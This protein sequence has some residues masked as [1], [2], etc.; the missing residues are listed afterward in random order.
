[1]SFNGISTQKEKPGL[2]VVLFSSSNHTIWAEEVLKQEGIEV[3]LIPVPR[4]LSADCGYCVQ[5]RSHDIPRIQMLFQGNS[6]KFD[7]IAAI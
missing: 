2:S 5:V 7:R 6:V 3:K 4:H 1:M